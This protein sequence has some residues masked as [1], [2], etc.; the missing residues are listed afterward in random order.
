MAR[1]L[2]VSDF[3]IITAWEFPG[4]P[5]GAM[6]LIQSPP[7]VATLAKKAT[8]E[9][10]ALFGPSVVS[11][12]D[13]ISEAHEV[14]EENTPAVIKFA[15]EFGISYFLAAGVVA[16][17]AKVPAVL[18]NGYSFLRGGVELSAATL[19]E[20]EELGGLFHTAGEGAHTGHSVY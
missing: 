18:A 13:R 7:L 2:S 10:E 8:T 5:A 19:A 20:V 4:A 3:T 1:G 15:V 16:A 14:Y 17:V 12:F 6:K 11:L 9:L